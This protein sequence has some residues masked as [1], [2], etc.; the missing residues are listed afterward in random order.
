MSKVIECGQPDEA[1]YNRGSSYPNLVLKRVKCVSGRS[2]FFL[3]CL[4]DSCS[5][6]VTRKPWFTYARFHHI[7]FKM[8]N[9]HLIISSLASLRCV[10]L[11]FLSRKPCGFTSDLVTSTRD[12]SEAK[13]RVLL[14][15]ARS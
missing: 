5:Y 12:A 1:E 15:V 13:S 11:K 4:S 14:L 2:G 3:D 6:C 7:A 10:I 8:H 9:N